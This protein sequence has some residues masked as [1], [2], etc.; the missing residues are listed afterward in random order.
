MRGYHFPVRSNPE[1]TFYYLCRYFLKRVPLSIV[2]VLLSLLVGFSVATGYLIN[3]RVPGGFKKASISTSAYSLAGINTD[4]ATTKK[5][6]SERYAISLG[7]YVLKQSF[8]DEKTLAKRLGQPFH[9]IVTDKRVTL[10]RLFLGTYPQAEADAV[11]ARIKKI[12]PDAFLIHNEQSQMVSVYG[13]SFFYQ[14]DAEK[15]EKLFARYDLKAVKV[16]TRLTLPLYSAC[17]G[18]FDTRA[19]AKEFLRSAGLSG[20]E[21]SVVPIL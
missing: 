21:T 18:D 2:I 10:T 7:A 9:V 8:E 12:S 1:A 17:M 16:P 15:Q 4:V 13:G 20:V 19:Q 5:N 14:S 3:D 6:S 11:L